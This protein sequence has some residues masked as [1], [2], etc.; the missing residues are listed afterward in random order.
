VLNTVTQAVG[1]GSGCQVWPLYAT[2]LTLNLATNSVTAGATRA[3]PGL[4]ASYYSGAYVSASM[5]QL[6]ASRY[7]LLH[8]DCA[9][10][11]LGNSS[12]GYGEIVTFDLAHDG[13]GM[14][15]ASVFESG[16]MTYVA[17]AK[18][19]ASHVVAAYQTG[20][21]SGKTALISVDTTS[22]VLST[23]A[24][25]AFGGVGQVHS[26]VPL[27]TTR[28]LDVY[29]GTSGAMTGRTITATISPT[30]SL[31]LGTPGTIDAGSYKGGTIFGLDSATMFAVYGVGSSTYSPRATL[32]TVNASGYVAVSDSM[33][34]FGGVTTVDVSVAAAGPL[35]GD[36]YLASYGVAGA[37]QMF[38]MNVDAIGGTLTA[39]AT[40]V[41]GAN[42]CPQIG[43]SIDATHALGYRIGADTKIAVSIVDVGCP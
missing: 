40:A 34:A 11:S 13:I 17:V 24:T 12:Q 19:D 21:N 9:N 28:F 31:T 38:S 7:V 39:G 37:G 41:C 3:I 36:H 33:T 29:R 25:E 32:F 27:S 10:M 23:I 30:P 2:L 14:S 15:P 5:V 1:S 35:V 43:G 20:G 8:G 4:N 18:V 42:G 16:W 6:D 26:L 22:Q